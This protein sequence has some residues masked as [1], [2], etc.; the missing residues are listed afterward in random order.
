MRRGGVSPPDAPATAPPA[1]EDR[2]PTASISSA[3]S[4]SAWYSCVVMGPGSLRNTDSKGRSGGSS[5]PS[6]ARMKARGATSAKRRKSSDNDHHTWVSAP[7][8]RAVTAAS[9]WFFASGTVVAASGKTARAL[10][11]SVR[12]RRRSSDGRVGNCSGP[13]SHRSMA[14]TAKP[15]SGWPSTAWNAAVRRLTWP[16]VKRG[17][18]RIQASLSEVSR[19]SWPIF[20]TGASTRAAR[21]AE[22]FLDRLVGHRRQVCQ[23]PAVV[24]VVDPPRARQHG[25]H[26][27][28]RRVQSPI[29]PLTEGGGHDPSEHRDASA[30]AASEGVSAGVIEAHGAQPELKMEAPRP[31][32]LPSARLWVDVR[33]VGAIDMVA[34][35]DQTFRQ[36]GCGRRI[37][38][39]DQAG[40]QADQGARRRFA[41]DHHTP[42]LVRGAVGRRKPGDGGVEKGHRLLRGFRLD[43]QDCRIALQPLVDDRGVVLPVGQEEIFRQRRIRRQAPFPPR[44]GQSRSGLRADVQSAARATAQRQAPS[45]ANGQGRRHRARGRSPTVRPCICRPPNGPFETTFAVWQT[46]RTWWP[47]PGPGGRVCGSH[48]RRPPCPSG[49]HAGRRVPIRTGQPE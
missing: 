31:R 20:R 39:D 12:P 37:E 22:D 41:A 28:R 21:G 42:A 34:G 33:A 7:S 18:S 5:A 44:L 27:R 49:R 4:R 35:F 9:A 14:L 1:V 3:Q 47:G 29:R 38:H 23:D 15:G 36:T 46:R 11:A 43:R 19:H 25:R 17:A 13:R 48:S 10:S 30:G 26:E 6:T 32:Q 8:R 24:V 16:S 45:P 40:P 2:R